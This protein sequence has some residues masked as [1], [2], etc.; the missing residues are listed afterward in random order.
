MA[1]EKGHAECVEAFRQH[2]A[3]VAGAAKAAAEAAATES[4]PPLGRWS[5][6]LVGDRA[7][8]VGL[9]GRP[10]LNGRRVR[11]LSWAGER[12][13]WCAQLEGGGSEQL[14]IREENLCAVGCSKVECWGCGVM[15]EPT[16]SFKCCPICVEQKLA[17][18][19]YFCSADC[20]KANWKDHKRWHKA[21]SDSQAGVRSM[22]AEDNPQRE[23][24]KEEAQAAPFLCKGTDVEEPAQLH[25][26][27][28]VA[29]HKQDYREAAKL[30]RKAIAR[31]QSSE[32]LLAHS[33]HLLAVILTRSSDIVGACKSALKAE[34]LQAQYR[35]L[36]ASDYTETQL[37][38][39]IEGWS[40][41]WGMAF[42][43]LRLVDCAAL[44]TP[45]WWNDSDLLR[46]SEA[47]ILNRPTE[48]EIDI[49]M[50]R[51]I[52]LQ[53]EPRV[54]RWLC[55]W[56]HD[57]RTA[58]QLYESARCFRKQAQL[59]PYMANQLPLDQCAASSERMAAMIAAMP[60]RGASG[61]EEVLKQMLSKIDLASEVESFGRAFR[62]GTQVF[63]HGLQR[64]PELN[65]S[66]GLITGYDEATMRYHLMLTRFQGD[67][68]EVALKEANLKQ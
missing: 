19:A 56:A 16:Q 12:S 27:A 29:M 42:S 40:Q 49:F 64:K 32:I 53:G 67:T 46:Y 61:E 4:A 59:I 54:C 9:A 33:Y 47:A 23:T 43:L 52:I 7:S 6:M 11:L 5:T 50:S 2:I 15:P 24:S 63:V 31:N 26:R 62:Q 17:T 48:S 28:S 13:R 25:A 34:Q 8:I 37:K 58:A 39:S 55:A 36:L 57:H 22:Y 35:G 30:C 45:P 60:A 14:L 44:A 18:P 66:P 3:T 68:K 1:K 51:A 65:G 21:Q 41:T 20:Q 10:A 38:A